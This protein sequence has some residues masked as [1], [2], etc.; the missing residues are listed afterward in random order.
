MADSPVELESHGRIRELRLARPPVN[1]LGRDMI[2]ALDDALAVQFED[3]SCGAI[4]I[5]GR[6]GIFSAGLDVR[7]VTGHRE[8]VESLVRAFWALQESLVRSPK[9][10]IAAITGHCPAGGMV[11]AMLCDHRVMARGDYRIGLNEVQVGLYPGDTV[12]RAYARLIG[13]AQAAALLPRGAMLDAESALAAGLVDEL[14]PIDLV[15]ERALAHAAGLLQLPPH[16]Y[17]RTRNLVRADLIDIYARP[18]ESLGQLLADGWAGEETRA[19]M[20]QVLAR[21][22]S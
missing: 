22:K 1:A 9:P 5:S 15:R 2:R 16:A 6:P 12:Y 3:P 20:A 13:T 17:S 4:V 10:I 8:S 18:R 7:E 14:A 21:S 19:A 11:I